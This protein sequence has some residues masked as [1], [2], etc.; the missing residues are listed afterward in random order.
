MPHS[1]EQEQ[2]DALPPDP[3]LIR[4]VQALARKQAAQDHE[5]EILERRLRINSQ[6]VDSEILE[7][8][9]IALVIAELSWRSAFDL[10]EGQHPAP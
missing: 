4:L 2:T 8:M 10:L 7:F 3:A 6:Q 5:Q 1:E 9:S